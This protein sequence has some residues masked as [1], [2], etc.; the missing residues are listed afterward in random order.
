MEWYLA[1]LKQYTRFDGR[2]HRTEF[3]WFTLWSFIISLALTIIEIAAG[4]GGD[5][6]GPLSGI[7]GLLVIIPTL[8]VGARRLHDIGRSG[9]WQLIGLIPLVGIIILIVWWARAG[10]AEPN[11]W[12]PNPWGVLQPAT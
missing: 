8:A 3:W 7:Y 6:G 11:E 4:L 9:W 12:G 10:D 1:V 2:S 5:W